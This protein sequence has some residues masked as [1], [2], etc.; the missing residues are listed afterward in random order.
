MDEDLAQEIMQ[1]LRTARE[2]VLEPVLYERVRAHR[3]DAVSPEHFLA[4][5]ERLMMGGRVRL[6]VEREP[7]VRAQPPFQ[8]RYY[9][10][11]D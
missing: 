5:L 2:P 6:S 9:R 8:A 7:R 3:A 11:A 4:V 10:S 1:R